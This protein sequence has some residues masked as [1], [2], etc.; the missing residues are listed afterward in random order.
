MIKAVDAIY[1][2]I[3]SSRPFIIEGIQFAKSKG[4]VEDE[5]RFYNVLANYYLFTAKLDSAEQ[6]FKFGLSL[7]SDGNN[8]KLKAAYTTNLG[9]VN[10]RLGK[11]EVARDYYTRSIEHERKAGNTEGEIGSKVNIAVT[12][13]MQGNYSK[14]I[15]ELFDC[16]EQLETFHAD[17][18]KPL[19]ADIYTNIAVNFSQLDDQEK[20]LDF[21]HK[22]Y[23]LYLKN[24]NTDDQALVLDNIITLLNQTRQFEKV[25]EYID[26]LATIA[27]QLGYPDYLIAVPLNKAY[28]FIQ[29]KDYI[30][31]ETYAKEALKL[32][33]EYQDEIKLYAGKS[34][35]ATAYFGQKK[36]RLA[37]AEYLQALELAEK[38]QDLGFVITTN[39]EISRTYAVLGQPNMAYDYLSAYVQLSDSLKPIESNK[40]AQ[41]LE[42]EYQTKVLIKDNQLKDEQFKNERIAKEKEQEKRKKAY[43]VTALL[44]ILVILIVL[45]SLQLRKRKQ[46]IEEKNDQLNTEIEQRKYY[47]ERYYESAG[48][49]MTVANKQS[50]R[51]ELNLGDIIY[52]EK[53]T[54]SN[55]AD[56]HTT[57]RQV[58]TK[59][60]V[61]SSI[62]D[63]EL[64]DSFFAQ[65]NKS[66]IINFHHLVYLNE[67][68]NKVGIHV[69]V[70]N[71]QKGKLETTTKEFDLYKQ[72][73]I[74][75]RFLSSYEEFKRENDLKNG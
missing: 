5:S 67:E 42:V 24:G 57:D 23:D 22:S 12:H 65:V 14:A 59:S 60:I 17:S 49:T 39:L 73:D 18:L 34:H 68:Q 47:Q 69:K 1:N 74:R 41:R 32:T 7:I 16:L 61:M 53:K 66:S 20:A 44:G 48:R 8:E 25:P 3:E 31:A 45:F 36:Y 71:K 28:Y 4:Y 52:I 40:I 11:F 75:K 43:W 70:L 54:G 15:Y 29:R 21:L 51:E 63:D 26:T 64:K 2:D 6:T 56:I 37:L 13:E 46:Q 50:K 58:Y 55:L 72:G 35:L 19:R 9:I 38:Y 62:V 10:R 33:E 30:R 27:E